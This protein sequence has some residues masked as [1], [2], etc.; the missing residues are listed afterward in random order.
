MGWVLDCG[1]RDGKRRRQYFKTQKE[2]EKAFHDAEKEQMAVGRRWAQVPAEQRVDVVTVLN[3]IEAAGHTLRDV[4]DGFRSGIGA[5]AGETKPLG[6][7][8]AELIKVKTAANRRPAYVSSLEQYLLRWAKGQE[9]KPIASVKLDEIDDFLNALPSLSSRMTAINRLS[10]LFSFA[11][12]RGWRADNPCERVERPHVEIGAPSIL[13]IEEAEKALEYTRREMPR[14]L[15]WLT[16]ALFAGVRPEEADKITWEAIDL[17]RG[18]VTVDSL[19]SKVRNRRI[20]HLKPVAVAWLRL[21]GD[22]P[23]PKVTRRRCIRELRE[24]LGWPAWKK[25]VLR[26]SAASYWLAS[27]PDAGRIAME[28]GNSPAVLLK[29]YREIVTDDQAKAFW[30]L[31][32]RKVG[33]T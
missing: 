27:D 10:T 7:A 4:W 2:V 29:H 19:T 8:I 30:A 12:R 33:K 22:L 26:H 5:T 17:D 9:A 3:E 13:T 16:L 11:V 18:V 20:V 1:Q 15:P 31:T 32:P 6:A 25:D 14:F 21:K 23:L 24:V 28:L